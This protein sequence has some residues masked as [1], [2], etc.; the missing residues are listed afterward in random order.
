M[1]LHKVAPNP[2]FRGKCNITTFGLEKQ[3]T[4]TAGSGE[5]SEIVVVPLLRVLHEEANR[6]T[7]QERR[8][9][10]EKG[11][12]VSEPFIDLLAVVVSYQYLLQNKTKI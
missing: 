5:G 9:C 8:S 12:E 1:P 6:Q 3:A 4:L 10:G 7:V 11:S 2:C